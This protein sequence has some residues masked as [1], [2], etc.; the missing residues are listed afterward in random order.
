MIC[1]VIKEHGITPRSDLKL[2]RIE[3][4][5]RDSVRVTDSEFRDYTEQIARHREPKD[6]AD[7]VCGSNCL[8][9]CGSKS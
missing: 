6:L 4:G 1:E 2:T 7:C 8:S 9:Q 5:G 3:L